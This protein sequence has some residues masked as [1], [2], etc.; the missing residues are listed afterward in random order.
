[1]SRFKWLGAEN[2]PGAVRLDPAKHACS[3]SG[4][5]RQAKDPNCYNDNK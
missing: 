1:M 3:V 5:S 2:L 4:V